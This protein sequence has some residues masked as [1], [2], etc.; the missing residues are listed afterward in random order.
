[1]GKIL[2]HEL[3]QFLSMVIENHHQLQVSSTEGEV[4]TTG[5]FN[6]KGVAPGHHSTPREDTQTPRVSQ[7]MQGVLKAYG[8]QGVVTP[9]THTT[10]SALDTHITRNAERYQARTHTI[11]GRFSDHSVS[12][13]RKQTST[14]K[15]L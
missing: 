6:L 3:K 9:V 4:W 2:T 8:L 13:V 7:W 10:G 5:D 1:M 14:L 15:Q 11:V 12:R